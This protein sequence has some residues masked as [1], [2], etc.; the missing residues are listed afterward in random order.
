MSTASEQDTKI[1]PHDL[2]RLTPRKAIRE[3]CLCC[4][5]S[6]PAVRDCGG[7]T[8]YDGPCLFYPYRLGRGRP[9]VKLI[10][11][12][13]LYCMG[14]SIKLVRECP[15]RTCPVLPYRMGKNPKLTG[16]RSGFPEKAYAR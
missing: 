8:L 16:R 5:G 12:H 7:D 15:S 4:V 9:S 14:G 11:R 6:A 10:R 3:L 1:S 2:G 13:C